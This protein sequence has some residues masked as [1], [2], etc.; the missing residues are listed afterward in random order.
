MFMNTS[1]RLPVIYSV[2]V[3]FYAKTFSLLEGGGS[4]YQRGVLIWLL[5]LG[6][7]LIWGECVYSRV[8][9]H[10]GKHGIQK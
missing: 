4:A 6:G 8:G 9:P 10:S 5:G 2:Q 7:E 3:R 1:T